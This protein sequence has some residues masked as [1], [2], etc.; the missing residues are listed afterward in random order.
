MDA[1]CFCPDLSLGYEGEMERAVLFPREDLRA[2]ILMVRLSRM[3]ICKTGVGRFD[4]EL[5][6]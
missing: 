5:E 6:D 2:L 1:D 4:D 3:M